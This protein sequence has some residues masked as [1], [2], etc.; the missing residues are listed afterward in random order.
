MDVRICID[1]DDMEAAVARL[2]ANGA[3][4][5]APVAERPYGRVAGLAD[6]FVHGLDLLE[7]RGRGYDELLFNR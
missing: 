4:L 6:P 1:V 2:L 3:T 5:E 7:F